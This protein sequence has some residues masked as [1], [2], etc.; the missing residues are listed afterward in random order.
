MTKASIS[1]ICHFDLETGSRGARVP[2][3]VQFWALCIF[4]FCCKWRYGTDR[5]TQSIHNG[6]SF[7]EGWPYNKLPRFNSKLD[8]TERLF[9]T[10]LSID[11]TIVSGGAVLGRLV[12]HSRRPTAKMKVVSVDGIPHLCLFAICDMTAGQQVVYDY[13]V[14]NLP[15]HDKV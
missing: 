10:V 9:Y 15:F 5:Q 3:R 14:K 4:S 1:I 7:Y 2:F 11:A 12:N 13:G 6:A 8:A